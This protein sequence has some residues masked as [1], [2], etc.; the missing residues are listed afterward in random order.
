MFYMRGQLSCHPTTKGTPA[1]SFRETGKEAG[2][3]GDAVVQVR[4]QPPSL[5]PSFLPETFPFLDLE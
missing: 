1:H 3:L 5:V 2:N 4:K